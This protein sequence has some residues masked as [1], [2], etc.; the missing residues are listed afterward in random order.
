VGLAS[1]TADFQPIIRCIVEIVEYTCRATVKSPRTLCS[2]A[3]YFGCLIECNILEWQFCES[4]LTDHKNAFLFITKTH[5]NV[6]KNAWK[7]SIKTHRF[8]TRRRTH[9]LL[10]N[11]RERV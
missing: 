8:K 3:G 1:K 4:A 2:V 6:H 11:K 7:K 5:E 10:K 9:R